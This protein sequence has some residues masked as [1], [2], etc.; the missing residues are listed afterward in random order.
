MSGYD[1]PKK[2]S[3]W[4]GKSTGRTPTVQRL[5]F[6][7]QVFGYLLCAK[8]LHQSTGQRVFTFTDPTIEGLSRVVVDYWNQTSGV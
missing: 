3:V 4:A 8:E 7:Q 6:I 5:V 2:P 1:T